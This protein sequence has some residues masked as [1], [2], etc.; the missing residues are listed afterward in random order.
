MHKPLKEAEAVL[1]VTASPLALDFG[2]T[3]QE[4]LQELDQLGTRFVC[5][6]IRHERYAASHQIELLAVRR[7]QAGVVVG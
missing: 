7:N 4:L 2:L 5:L 3:L 6:R 1:A